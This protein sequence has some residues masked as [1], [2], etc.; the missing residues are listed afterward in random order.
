MHVGH[1]YPFGQV[2]R[3]TRRDIARHTLVAAL[4]V[5]CYTWLGWRWLAVPWLPIALL[6]TAVACVLSASLRELN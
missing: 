1:H 3:W 2:L 4:V 5:A 6:G